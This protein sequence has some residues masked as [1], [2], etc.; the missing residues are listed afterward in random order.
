[1]ILPMSG[2]RL[3]L[4]DSRQTLPGYFNCIGRM[5]P[6]SPSQIELFHLRILFLHVR[7][8]TSFQE[9]RTVNNKVHQTFT[10]TCLALRLIEDDEEWCRAMN[11]AKIWM[12]PRRLCNLFVR[13]LIY[14]Q[15]VHPKKLWDEFKR[16]MSEDY[17]R[18]FGPIIGIKKAYN[19]IIN[20]LQM[21]GSNITNFSEMEQITEEQKID[22]EEQIKNTSTIW[23]IKCR[24]KT[25]C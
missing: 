13:I 16:D 23:T 25:N 1:M 22:N 9:L 19:Y 20:L 6:V 12:M 5:Y 8:A 2:R 15:P 10:A 18:R 3:T 17:I 11:E 21:E 14:C 7:G 24:T 4:G